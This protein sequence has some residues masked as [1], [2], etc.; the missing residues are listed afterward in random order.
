MENRLDTI[1]RNGQFKIFSFFGAPPPHPPPPG[2]QNV[3]RAGGRGPHFDP[4]GPGGVGG[5]SGGVGGGG[6]ILLFTNVGS[7][8]V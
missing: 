8:N 4:R 5:A 1:L 2:D 6:G 3:G 7:I